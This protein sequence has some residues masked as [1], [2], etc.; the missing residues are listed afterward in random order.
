MYQNNPEKFRALGREFYY[1]RK[2]KKMGAEQ[3]G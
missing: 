3:Q 2:Q 1:R